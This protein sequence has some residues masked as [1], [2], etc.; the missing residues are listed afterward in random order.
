V[1]F[2]LD[3]TASLPEEYD[4]CIAGGGAAGITLALELMGGGLDVCVLEGGGREPTDRSQDAYRGRCD[5]PLADGY[6]DGSRLRFLGGTTNHWL[7]TWMALDRIDFEPREWVSESGW[8]FVREELEPYY[9]RAAERFGLNDDLLEARPIFGATESTDLET[10]AFV[11][12]ATRF[13]TDLAPPIEAAPDVALVLN[14]N[15]VRIAVDRDGRRVHSFDVASYDGR[16]HSIRADKYVLAL[17][18]IENA[19]MLLASRDVL[20]QGIGNE[21]DRVGRCFVEH[22]VFPVGAISGTPDLNTY[23]TDELGRSALRLSDAAQRRHRLLNCNLAFALVPQVE[24]VRHQLLRDVEWR[25]LRPFLEERMPPLRSLS[26]TRRARPLHHLPAF[27]I[28]P[29]AR[30]VP[31]S[32]LFLDETRHDAFGV[33]RLHLS[34]K[35]TPDVITAVLETARLVG[36]ELGRLGIGRLQVDVAALRRGVQSPGYH[37]MG[38]TR[39]HH[40][41]RLGVVDAE[42]RVHGLENLFVAGSSVF[43]NSGAAN[44]TY[45]L[46]AL[47]IRLADR[48]KDSAAA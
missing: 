44:P 46:V 32:R 37:H 26:S 4:V 42:C 20:R 24:D 8:P 12:R 39:A 38:T 36:V 29:E 21:H 10:K 5:A 6:L 27:A 40:D 35:L 23:L 18:G 33:P 25:R 41:P 7:G 14:A 43:P 30:P 15:L 34:W 3:S 16:R 48:L 17:G 28:R 2:D 47:A 1:L 19:R 45:T 9:R 13:G 11:R 22:P 31:E